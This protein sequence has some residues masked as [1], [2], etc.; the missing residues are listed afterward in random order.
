MASPSE[1]R[2]ESFFSDVARV[3]KE[4]G[5]S[6]SKTHQLLTEREEVLMSELEELENFYKG[7]K[8]REQIDELNLLKEFQ[9]ST[10]TKNE[11]KDII[12]QHVSE[13]RSHRTNQT[14]F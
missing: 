11:N 8:I 6:F 12:T 10:V 5:T 3:R 4:I 2:E 13:I 14:N 9:M 7:V 1:A